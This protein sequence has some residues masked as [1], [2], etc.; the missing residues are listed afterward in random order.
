MYND[1]A[2]QASKLV[3]LAF[4]LEP[5]IHLLLSGVPEQLIV[6]L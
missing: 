1:K 3:L 4:L 6:Q 2:H 5:Y